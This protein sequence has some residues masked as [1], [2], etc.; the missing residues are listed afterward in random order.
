MLTVVT[1][2]SGYGGEFFADYLSSEVPVLNIIRVI[3]WHHAKEYLAST[4]QARKLAESSLQPYIGK[5]D[6]IVFANHLLSASSLKYF[7]RKYPQQK[8]IGLSLKSP[9]TFIKYDA[10]VI[11]TKALTRT[12][13]YHGFIYRLK[14]RVGTLVVDSW[15]AKIDEG[16]LDPQE[17]ADTVNAFIAKKHIRPKEVIL[18]NSGLEEIKPTLKKILG[19]NVRIYTSFDD[20]IREVVKTLRIRG[21]MKKK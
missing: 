8:F 14:R 18:A 15:P 17:I 7:R 6:L 13:E 5:V 3:D 2:D 21:G 9:D 16:E 10:L 4:R 20:A 11:T 1:I 19:H 12:M